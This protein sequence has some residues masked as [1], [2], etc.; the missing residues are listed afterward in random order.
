VTPRNFHS[1]YTQNFNFNIQQ[2]LAQ[3]ASIEARYVG[4]KGTK[5]VRLTDLNEPDANG[6]RPNPNYSAI[7]AL[8]PSSSS[9]YSALQAIGRLENTHGVS[10]FA[11]YVW[12]KAI[13]DASDGID[14]VPGAA[15]PQD[16]GNLAAE[17]GPSL[18][19]TRQRFTAAINYA[20]PSWKAAR[21]F[22]SGW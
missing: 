2:R 4:S 13:D 7:D 17:R 15:F 1:P 3:N 10:G 16:P 20:L 8:T 18:F 12:S 5:L 19:D 21:G 11:A 22:G 14:F 9:S 6:D